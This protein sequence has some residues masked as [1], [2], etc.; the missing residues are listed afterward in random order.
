MKVIKN[1]LSDNAFCK[2]KTD[3]ICGLRTSR[4][5][6]SK[7]FYL[8]RSILLLD[9]ITPDFREL[10]ILHISFDFKSFFFTLTLRPSKQAF[11]SVMTSWKQEIVAGGGGKSGEN[12]PHE[13]AVGSPI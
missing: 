3:S 9:Q 4:H 1:V 8:S 11:V 12:M 5:L 13:V 7:D 6:S 2:Y 10:N